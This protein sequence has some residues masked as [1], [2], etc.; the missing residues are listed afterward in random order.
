LRSLLTSKLIFSVALLMAIALS[1]PLMGS[2]LRPFAV[3][4]VSKT[5]SPAKRNAL[6]NRLGVSLHASSGAEIYCNKGHT[7]IKSAT[8][9]ITGNIASFGTNVDAATPSEDRS[10]AG[11]QAVGQSETS[12][13]GID[14]YVVEAWNDSTGFFAPCPSP[15]SKEEATGYGFSTNSGKS[16]VD[17]GG[18]PNANCAND[19]YFGDP[20]VEAWHSGNSDYFYISSLYDSFSWDTPS[21]MALT[22]CQVTGTG[23]AAQLHCSQPVIAATNTQCDQNNGCGFL[24]KEYL[25]I[26]PK[27][28][29][30]YMSYTEFGSD[31]NNNLWN[32]QIELSVCDIGT[33]AG[34][35][36]PIG[37]TA[38]TPVCE[39]G[40]GTAPYYVVAPAGDCV[41]QGSYPAVDVAQ[42]DVYVAYEFNYFS[43]I[44]SCPFTPTQNIVSYVP[45]SCLVLASVSSCNTT[46]RSESVN[47]VSM[48]VSSIIGYSRWSLND[49]PR[50]AVSD[51]ANTVSMVWNDA[52]FHPLGDILLQSFSLVNLVPVQSAPLKINSDTTGQPHLLPSVRNADAHGKLNIIWYDRRSY[53]TSAFTDV[54]AALALDP[55]ALTTPTKNTLVTSAPTNWLNVSSDIDPNFGD[56]TDSYVKATA[57]SPYT[58]STL[59]AAWSDGRLGFPQPF[60]ASVATS[61]A[62]RHSATAY[63]LA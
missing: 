7:S 21:Y 38:A 43:N 25:S 35:P 11:V 61:Q 4:A 27:H 14:S 49:F 23:G 58:G 51:Q 15:M 31:P 46:P 22:A 9:T 17:E 26:D 45:S 34:N 18:L 47:I 37:G 32:G 40:N 63:A 54:Y 36:G 50:I 29:R 12:I 55:R 57:N 16:F 42:G 53:T 6:C 3:H 59:Y 10:P 13:A 56:Y 19:L 44:S 24:D 30:L 33:P 52:R 48:L 20:S 28:G 41:N 60:A 5:V 1:A 39:Q 62:Q 2:N 8:K